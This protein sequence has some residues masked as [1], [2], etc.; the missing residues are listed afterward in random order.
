MLDFLIAPLFVFVVLAGWLLVQ[1]MGRAFARRHPEF[2]PVRLRAF[3]TY[4][5]RVADPA[6]F[7]VF[8]ERVVV[9]ADPAVQR[10]ARTPHSGG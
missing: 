10:C 7:L 5:V 8:T 2:G 1:S 3:G 6:R 4:T 9:F